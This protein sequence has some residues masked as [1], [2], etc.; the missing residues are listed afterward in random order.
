MVA[1][2]V[3]LVR[4]VCVRMPHKTTFYDSAFFIEEESGFAATTQ[5]LALDTPTMVSMTIVFAIVLRT[6]V[7][8]NMPDR[9]SLAMTKTRGGFTLDGIHLC[10]GQRL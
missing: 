6:T 8:A 4:F 7:D 2:P 1:V 5:L 3:S 10:I 9:V